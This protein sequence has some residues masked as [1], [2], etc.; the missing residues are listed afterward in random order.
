MKAVLATTPEG[1]RNFRIIVE[2]CQRPDEGE[3]DALRVAVAVLTKDKDFTSVNVVLTPKMGLRISESSTNF[4]DVVV[5]LTGN[6]FYPSPAGDPD[7]IGASPILPEFFQR[8]VGEGSDDDSEN[9]DDYDGG[10]ETREIEDEISDGGAENKKE[11]EVS[12]RTEPNPMSTPDGKKAE[13]EKKKRA[14][15]NGVG[16]VSGKRT[17]REDGEGRGLPKKKSGKSIPVVTHPSGLRYQNTLIGA[18]KPTQ[19]G[20]SVAIQYVLRLDNGKVVDK[21]DRKRPFKF[22]LGIGESIKGMD[23]GILGM[24]E[25]GER[26]IVVPPELGYGDR[27]L[28]GIPANSTLYFDV[29]VVKA[30]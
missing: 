3:S 24:R 14:D 5:H 7:M 28:P 20:H 22:R 16:N 23:I 4:A 9:D 25:G 13:Q 17:T 26:H 21:A 15:K 18:G 19:N 10:E 30:F 27:S 29:T 1:N 2:V 11:K 6:T 12:D 8:I